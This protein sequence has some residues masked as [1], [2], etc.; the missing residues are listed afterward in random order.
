MARSQILLVRSL[1]VIILSLKDIKG[2]YCFF[3]LSLSCCIVYVTHIHVNALNP[4]KPNI[5][6]RLGK[7]ALL[8]RRI[9]IYMYN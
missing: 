3:F 7:H 2:N 6:F 1:F 4:V 8:Y 9:P 5:G